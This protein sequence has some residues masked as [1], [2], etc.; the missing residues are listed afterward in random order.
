MTNIRPY[1]PA[2]PEFDDSGA[3]SYIVQAQNFLSQAVSQTLMAQ[4]AIQKRLDNVERNVANFERQIRQLASN[5]DLITVVQLE[6][7]LQTS[8]SDSERNSIGTKLSRYSRKSGSAPRKIP[9]PTIPG[10][11]NG[12]EPRL[13]KDWLE[14]ETDY[15]VPDVLRYLG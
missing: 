9:H 4:G 14:D 8:W 3:D 1:Y 15:R 11:V 12:Y 6:V 13:V 10:G 5:S 2:V 7:M